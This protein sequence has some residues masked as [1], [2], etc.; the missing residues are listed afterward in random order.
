MKLERY[1]KVP[2]ENI[3]EGDIFWGWG[4]GSVE[5]EVGVGE[6]VGTGFKGLHL[7]KKN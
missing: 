3:V 6:A 1:C 5:M 2:F 4:A 7:E